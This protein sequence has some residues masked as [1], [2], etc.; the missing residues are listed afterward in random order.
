MGDYVKGRA[1]VEG[2]VEDYRKSLRQ[3]IIEIMHRLEQLSR[4]M[5]FNGRFAE[6]ESNVPE[7][8]SNFE[9]SLVKIILI[10]RKR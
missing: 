1:L 8:N 9:K 2:I 7:C 6:A 5:L 3:E 10:M 4:F